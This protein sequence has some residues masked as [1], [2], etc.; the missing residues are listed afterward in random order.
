MN[1]P[2]TQ[3]LEVRYVALGATI[4][5]RRTDRGLLRLLGSGRN[6]DVDRQSAV[7]GIPHRFRSIADLRIAFATGITRSAGSAQPSSQSLWSPPT[8]AGSQRCEFSAL[9]NTSFL[10]VPD[11]ARFDRRLSELP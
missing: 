5:D 1:R 2:E 7:C 4:S 6:G 11:R 9:L 10:T 8:M 3:T